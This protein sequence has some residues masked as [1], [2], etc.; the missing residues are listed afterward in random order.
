MGKIAF[1]TD[2][3]A[4]LTP[5]QAEQNGIHVVPL[6]VIFE[7]QS[8]RE[9]VDIAS[10]EFYARLAEAKT[11][12]T[13]SQPAPGEF[14]R[15]FER[16]LQDHDSVLCLL[17]SGGLSGTVRSAETAAQMVGGDVTVV[18]SRITSYGIAGPLLD[19]VALARQGGTKEDILDLWQKELTEMRAYFVIDT[20]EYLHRGGRIGGA[21][22]AFGALLQ[23]KP[24]LTMNDG[25]IDL[26]EKVRTH[27]RAMERMLAQFD[28]AAATGQPL[29]VGVVHSRR[30]DDAIQLRDELV[31]KYPNIQAEISELGPVIGTHTGPGV[32]A[33]IYYPRQLKDRA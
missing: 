15:V 25:R 9:G 17:L 19:G 4:Y 30:L 3:T 12:P 16:L 14:A 5:E 18:D 13:T 11:L 32:L 21:A 33:L 26:F 1:V 7:D 27:R 23:I 31:A 28:S 2:S 10:D 22:A 6:S 20:L 24:I 29:Q 8:Y